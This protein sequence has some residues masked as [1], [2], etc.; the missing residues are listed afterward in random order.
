[1]DL[2][3]A[4][5]ACVVTGASGGIGG[6]VAELLAREGA[7]TLLVGRRGPQL[8]AVAQRCST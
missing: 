1:M 5:R 6:A 4:D 2:G 7:S 3:L 8:E